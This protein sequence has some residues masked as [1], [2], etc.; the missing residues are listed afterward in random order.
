M[1]GPGDGLRFAYSQMTDTHVYFYCT[2]RTEAGGKDVPGETKARLRKLFAGFGPIAQQIIEAADET[3][4]IR[5]D[6][7]DFKPVKSWVKGR[8]ALLGD[9]A[10]ATT[11]NLGQGGAQAVEDAYVIAQALAEAGSID[12]ALRRYQ[13]VRMEK[14]T[15]VVNAS[16]SYGQITNWSNPIATWLRDLLMRNLP[17]S[18]GERQIARLYGVNF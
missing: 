7:F 6:L 5:T 11:P 13:A 16:W 14:A 9:A 8:V 1:W 12:E 4:I 15:H 3:A 2:L 17:R 18:L 10:H